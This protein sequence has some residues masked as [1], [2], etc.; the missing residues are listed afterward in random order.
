MSRMRA[1]QRRPAGTAEEVF[2]QPAE[3]DGDDLPPAAENIVS[4]RPAAMLGTTRS[5]DWRF[6]STI[7]TISPSSCTDGSRIASHTAPSSSS[8]SRPASTAVPY[9]CRPAWC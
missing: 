5:S 9:P 6:M 8:A 2:E 4:S 7:Q 3:P 1:P